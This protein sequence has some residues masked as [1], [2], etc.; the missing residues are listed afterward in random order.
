[1]QLTPSAKGTIAFVL[2]LALA[3]VYCNTNNICMSEPRSPLI[4][5]FGRVF[6]PLANGAVVAPLT[7]LLIGAVVFG[8]WTSRRSAY[9]L[10][11]VIGLVSLVIYVLA[12][13]SFVLAGSFASAFIC[14]T[15][16]ACAALATWYAFGGWRDRVTAAAA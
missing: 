3:I 8:V 6:G 7:L 2:A 14:G 1:M 12:G 10:G 16:I 4:P 11:G 15:V 13:L 5:T 9:A